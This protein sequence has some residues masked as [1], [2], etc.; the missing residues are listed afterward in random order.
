MRI[1]LTATALALAGCLMATPLHADS[2]AD[3]IA[4]GSA[5]VDITPEQPLRLSGYGNRLEPS[6]GIAQRLWV[7]GVAIGGDGGEPGPAVL[8]SVENCALA[9][10]MVERVAGRITERTRIPRRRISITCT[11]T[12][13]APALS[14]A[15]GLIIRRPFL[16]EQR[17]A[18][19]H[20]TERVEDAIVEAAERA[21]ANRQPARLS[22]SRGEVGFAVNR[23]LIRD[24]QWAGFG[25]RE[26]GPI[27]HDLPLLTARDEDGK[28]L[29][30][31]FNYACH[32]TTM[33]GD[34][35]QI[36]GDW[37]GSAAGLIEQRH[38]GAVAVP[39]IGCAGDQNPHPRGGSA[40]QQIELAE[41]HGRE[42][43]D[44]VDRLL[45]EPGRAIASGPVGRIERID[46]PYADVPP[47]SEWERRAERDDN[48]GLLARTILADLD[49]GE[50][51][52]DAL[53]EYPMQTWTFDDDLAM[54][55]LAGE[56][57]A[58]YSLRLKEEADGDRL[59]VTAYANG[60]PC[61][62]ATARAINR[63]GYEVDGSMHYYVRPSRL[64][65]SVE[66]RIINTIKR[67]LPEAYLE[68]APEQTSR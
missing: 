44:E 16:E 7:R 14:G 40:E 8:L 53:R 37:A 56:V 30:A 47:R 46:L 3:T 22:W 12:H 19:E 62:I 55:F 18:I 24:G 26:E 51:V 59:W 39:L 48:A 42:V 15:L 17:E 4:I 38:A 2:S 49:E 34:V 36:H 58:G 20:Y 67:M 35:Y 54:V 61:Y 9:M 60:V 57:L 68:E 65:P 27:D 64:D 45:E 5:K 66:D 23:R 13:S 43:A 41:R 63:G 11:H 1:T 31:V 6:Q 28:L 33:G 21:L 50:P 10:E 32:C 25:V 52:P 29:A